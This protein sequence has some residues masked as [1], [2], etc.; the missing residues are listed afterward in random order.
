MPPKVFGIQDQL[1]SNELLLML[2][3]GIFYEFL[4][5]SQID[6]VNKTPLPLDQVEL[7]TNYAMLI[8]TN[9]GL[10]RYMIGDTVEFT[11]LSP[12]RIR[13]T[14]RTKSFIN[15][16]G[17]EV[18]IDNAETALA[19]ACLSTKAIVSEYT[20]APVFFNNTN[21]AAHEWVI[22]F[23]VPPKNIDDFALTLDQTLQSINS[24]YEAKRFNDMVL[25]KPI[26]RVAP[27][28]TFYKWLKKRGKL[29]GKIKYLACR[30]T[31]NIWMNFWT[32]LIIKIVFY[33]PVFFI[34][35][36]H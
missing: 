34:F 2:D 3:Y 20:A 5:I 16:V 30:M 12:Y 19:K 1:D 36:Y 4:P 23:E 32:I 26:L 29:G 10:W 9:A 24:D 25:G 22:E 21:T 6:A 17:E 18:I 31:E 35:V 33:L 14:G 28:G 13:I 7:K 11:S 15:A 27:K 8:T